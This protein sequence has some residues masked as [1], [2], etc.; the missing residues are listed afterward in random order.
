MADNVV[1]D[2][3]S[4][5]ATIAT[6]DIDGFHHQ[7]MKPGHGVDGTTVDTSHKDPLPVIAGMQSP[8][9]SHAT[10]AAL[11]A[12]GSTDLDS[13]QIT[14]GATGKLIAILLWSS[15]ACKGQVQTVLNGAASSNK[16]VFGCLAG[17]PSWLTLPSRE[18]ITQVEDATA[19]LDGFRVRVTNLETSQAADVYVT[20]FYDERS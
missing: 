17:I 20:F 1:L 10:V 8:Q 14:S 13:A 7:R 16:A 9:V 3:G 15:V 12:G 5:G 4:G 2:P 11:A 18:F 19:G 6:D